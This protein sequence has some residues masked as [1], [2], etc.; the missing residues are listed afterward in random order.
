MRY[1]LYDSYSPA[2]IRRTHKKFKE[3]TGEH[4]EKKN[5]EHRHQTNVFCFFL[6]KMRAKKKKKL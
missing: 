5:L 2:I 1:D 4:E 6:N 3:S